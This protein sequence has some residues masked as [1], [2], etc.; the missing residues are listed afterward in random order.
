[1]SDSI[2]IC[3]FGIACAIICVIIRN[4]KNE[5]I[6]PTRVASLIILITL[7]VTLVTPIV[8]FLNDMMGQTLPIEYMTLIL[9]SLSIG[10]VT[11]ISSELCRDCGENNIASAIESIGTIEIIV[12]SIP[13]IY[14][15]IDLSQ[16]LV[17]W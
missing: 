3:L 17:L 16:E 8:E 14:K 10:Y 2:K 1:M 9:K 6:I 4:Y 12:L 13:L 11:Q 15:I 7:I 5:F